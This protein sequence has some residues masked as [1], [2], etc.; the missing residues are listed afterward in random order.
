MSDHI[1]KR[2]IKGMIREDV[3]QGWEALEADQLPLAKHHF[4]E[5]ANRVD[6]LTAL[7]NE[8]EPTQPEQQPL[9]ELPTNEQN[10]SRP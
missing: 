9:L 7:A 6:E 1:A 3:E 2:V 5:A 8:A 4:T 10:S